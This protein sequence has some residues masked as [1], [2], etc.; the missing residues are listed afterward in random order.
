MKDL[1]ASNTPGFSRYLIAPAMV[2]LIS[3]S[4]LAGYAGGNR[5]KQGIQIASTEPVVQFD[6]SDATTSHLDKDNTTAVGDATDPVENYKTALA[7]LTKNRYGDAIDSK[8]SRQLTYEA[9]RGMVGSLRDMF[10]SFLDPDEWN[11]M[12]ATTH[13]DF[14]GIGAY[15]YQDPKNKDIKVTEPIETGPAE[16]E[17]IK[18]DDVITRVDGK[19]VIGQDIN[20]VI[21][22]IKGKGGTHVRIG[23]VRGKA[24]MEFDITRARVEP[25]IVKYWMEDNQNKIGHILLKEFNEKSVEQMNHAF[26][27]LEK[28][29]MKALVFDLRYNPGG[30]L[31]TAIDVASILIPADKTQELHNVAVWIKEGSGRENGRQLRPVDTAY[32]NHVPMVV[33]VN[34][35]SASASE[36]VTGAV[37][38]Y[39]AGTI[40]GGRTYGK[41]RVQ[42][43]IPME[44]GSA[45]RLTTSLYFP[46]KHVDLNF[47]HDEDGNRIPKTGGILPDIDVTQSEKWKL[48]DFKDKAHDTQLN[49]ALDF[50][51]A[52]LKGSTIAQATAVVKP[53]QTKQ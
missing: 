15:L 20:D 23:I 24:P 1:K 37:K 16:K 8:K 19:S 18:P 4:L 35:N 42:T 29:G 31:E 33:L 12:L 17:G 3:V 13:G 50:L 46:P 2:G 49:V 43:L 34:D 21:K 11:Q 40:I 27:D 25:P 32:T 28:Q 26:E 38:D 47:K 36:I 5:Q 44:D 14:E 10:S 7:L 6:V 52:R 41:G 22:L 9:I 45:L 39:G 51:R 48:E 53:K 30:L